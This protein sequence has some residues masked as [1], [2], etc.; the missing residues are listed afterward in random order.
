MKYHRENKNDCISISN[1]TIALILFIGILFIG[2]CLVCNT[3]ANATDDSN[4]TFQPIKIASI[5]II[6]PIIRSVSAKFGNTTQYRT[7][8]IFIENENIIFRKFC[9]SQQYDVILST[10]TMNQSERYY[11]ANNGFNNYSSLIVGY[12]AVVIVG[13]N[14][15]PS[16]HFSNPNIYRIF[17]KYVDQ[18]ESVV[19]NR[20]ANWIQIDKSLKD[21]PISI[22]I[23]NEN[24]FTKKILNNLVSNYCMSR[25]SFRAVYKDIDSLQQICRQIREDQNIKTISKSSNVIGD[26]A[27]NNR[28]FGILDFAYY[29]KNKDK[30]NV[31]SV[32]FVYPTVDNI[33]NSTYDLSMPIILYYKIDDQN[34][35]MKT[36]IKFIQDR[37]VSGPN[38][39]LYQSGLLHISS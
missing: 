22:Q 26:M 36:F 31:A 20:Y 3:L 33:K 15:Q 37:N 29:Y 8:E 14:N 27:T 38:G 28:L 25:W 17:S 4:T 10:R 30:F 13:P 32:E 1:K 39:F 34:S 35:S 18:L 5:Q 11:C 12:N 24:I 9:S 7:P 2:T 23:S 21:V 19:Y 16:Y 6:E